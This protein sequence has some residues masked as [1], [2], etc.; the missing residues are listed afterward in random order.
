MTKRPPD[1]PSF[2]EDLFPFDRATI[3]LENGPNRGL[4]M[5]YVDHGPRDSCAVWLQHGNPTWSFLWRKVIAELPHLRVIAP[6]LLGCGLTQ[7]LLKPGDHTLARHREALSEL[8]DRLRIERVVLVGQDWGGP[9]V[10]LLG[11]HAPER[12]A[13]L[14]LGNTSILVPARPRGAGFHRFAATPVLSDLVFRLGAFPLQILDRTQGDRSSISGE[15]ARA[16]RWPFGSWRDRAAPLGL[17]RMVPTS[18]DHPSLP[19][20]LRGEE[21]AL[22]FDGPIELIWGLRDP[23]LGRALKRH[24]KRFPQA[25]VTRTEAGHFLQEEVPEEFVRAIREIVE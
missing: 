22:S 14:V 16:Y 23:I 18:P 19:L 5:H 12:V 8:F 9:L 13:G 20:L 2:L 6:D 17:A 21:W 24:E 11:A 7:K 3:E 15:I 25:R 1:L 10:A 4:L